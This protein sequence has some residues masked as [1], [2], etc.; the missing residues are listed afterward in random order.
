VYYKERKYSWFS[1]RLRSLVFIFI[2]SRIKRSENMSSTILPVR[3]VGTFHRFYTINPV[4]LAPLV[5]ESWFSFV[6]HDFVNKRFVVF[7]LII[8]IVFSSWVYFISN[9]NRII[10]VVVEDAE[11]L[12]HGLLWFAIRELRV[13]ETGHEFE[14][15]RHS[16]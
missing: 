6:H 13:E 15:S 7:Y 8:F 9:K 2:V 11:C 3:F 14:L 10:V 16:C 5:E 1:I 4:M 12:F